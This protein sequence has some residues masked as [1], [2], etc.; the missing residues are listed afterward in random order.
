MPAE[1]LPWSKWPFGR[2]C[3]AR[4]E[5]R[6]GEGKWQHFGRCELAPHGPEIDHA[7]ERGFDSPRWSTDWTDTQP[8]TTAGR[9]REMTRSEI[10]IAIETRT[11]PQLE[12]AASFLLRYAGTPEH[13]LQLLAWGRFPTPCQCG[14]EGCEG[15]AMAQD[16]P[17]LL[18]N[19]AER[20]DP[21]T[22][23]PSGE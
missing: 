1:D 19:L 16:V 8:L 15:W 3:R 23:A 13:A 7:L 9:P 11:T 21:A 22:Q 14:E 20:T 4:R 10:A 2:R 17:G 18:A 5:P 12:A 6:A